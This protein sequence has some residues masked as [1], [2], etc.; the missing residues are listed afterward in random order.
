MGMLCLSIPFCVIPAAAL[1]PAQKCE[2]VAAAAL[3][4][5]FARASSRLRRCYRKT[6]AAC[7][8]TD[9]D[10]VRS[11]VEKKVTKKC[12]DA[13]VQS[14]GYGPTITASSLVARL[15][16]ACVGDAKS[17]AART[18]GG[19]QAAVLAAGTEEDADCLDEAYKRAR[20]LIK[21]AFK[22]QS[23]CVLKTRKGKTC[24]PASPASKVA[25]HTA[26]A[27]EKIAARCPE[28]ESLIGLDENRF[29]DR[30]LGQARCMVATVH[31]DVSPLSLD[32]GLRSAVPAPARG[33]WT[34]V[35][36][37]QSE[38][39]TKCGDGSNYAFQLRLAPNGSAPENV[40]I[41]L[42]G[43]GV[44]LADSDCMNV[45]A[46]LFEALSETPPTGGFNSTNP[47]DNP[48]WDWTML[49]LP[50]CTQDVHFGGGTTSNFPHVTVERYGAINV[51]AALRYLRDVLWAELDATTAEG[52]RPDRLRVIFSG[53]SAGGFGVMYNHHYPLD[54]LRWVHTT[55]VPDS[56]LALDN[57][58]A[59]GLA[60]LG[61]LIGPDTPPLGWGTLP[62]QPPYCLATNCAVGEV[63]EAA[64]SVRLKAVPEQQILNVSNQVDNTQRATTFFSSQ[65]AWTQAARDAYCSLQGSN[66]IRFF[67]P[68]SSTSTHTLLGSTS[69]FNNTTS[70]GVALRDWLE[71]AMNDPGGV[72]DRV[73]EGS[74]ASN[75]EVEPFGCSVD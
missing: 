9:L 44:C 73:E 1:T 34:Q 26:A 62:F 41:H 57:G 74:L 45:S 51:R 4:S 24:D 15:Q 8:E 28:L 54:D 63:L 32:C 31:P 43:G 48:F 12:T 75:P 13:T 25:K 46:D 70:D 3:R 21:K 27:A 20:I 52:F 30:A 11:R 35:V 68:A 69:R 38:W 10:K 23:S 71:A 17:L 39:G 7:L 6:G 64:A 60:S 72:E 59:F 5:C 61:A 58:E 47:A 16:E 29:T 50:Y 36:L 42:Q 18:Y 65:G 66:G 67:L 22:K 37:D 56:S 14:L 40:L 19:P 49:F 2:K 53:L 33:A 55:I